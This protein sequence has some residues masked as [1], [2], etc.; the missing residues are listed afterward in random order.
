MKAT[1]DQ[2]VNGPNITM[3]TPARTAIWKA[4]P[5]VPPMN[6]EVLKNSALATL[7]SRTSPED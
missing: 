5:S 1:H 4:P 2:L 7:T 6:A 3:G